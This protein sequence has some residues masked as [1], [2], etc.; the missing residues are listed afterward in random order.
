MGFFANLVFSNLS[1]LSSAAAV[2]AAV[3]MWLPQSQE[4]F[5]G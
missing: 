5:K 3:M 4:H 1:L 2:A